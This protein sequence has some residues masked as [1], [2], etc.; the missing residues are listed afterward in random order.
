MRPAWDG[1]LLESGS[2][3]GAI[4]REASKSLAEL[5]KAVSESFPALLLALI[6]A[7]GSAT[8]AAA[9]SKYAGVVIDAKTGK[10]LYSDRA[11]ARRYPAS[12][13]KM[14]TLYLVFDALQTGR[15][16]MGTRIPVSRNAA[17]EVPS[18]LGLKPGQTITVRQ[19]IYALVTKSANDA[20]TAIGEFLGGS[21]KGFARMMTRRAHQ[22]GM[23]RTT[24][25]NA[26]GLPN[27]QQKTTAHDMARLG[28]ALREHHAKY[29][30]F[31][32]TRSFAYNGHRYGN[33]NR[34]LGRVKGVDGI[35]TGYTRASGFN[36]VTSVRRNGRSIVAVVMGG[37]TGR[38]RD[39]HM[40]DLIR[41]YLPRA[42]TGADR[43]LIARP[44]LGTGGKRVASVMLPASR[45]PVPRK[46]PA[47]ST[48]TAYADEPEAVGDAPLLAATGPDTPADED[49]DPVA[50]A[51]VGHGPWAIQVASL[52]SKSDALSFLE[53][54]SKAAPTVLANAEPFTETF[55]KDGTVYHRARYGGFR[56]KD[57]AWNACS[58]LKRKKIACYAIAQ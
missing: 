27:P 40:A 51:S 10:V 32:S 20:A 45:V 46:R 53:N 4:V 47:L 25:R 38:S 30:H 22:L 29:Y 44:A 19:V 50:T 36:L 12:L 41:R 17:S 57:A 37:R 56:S 9:N 26:N 8:G 1:R 24:F 14:M 39:R 49:L 58:A 18:K 43:D 52:P 7:V 15:I 54:T 11:E 3:W 42:S 21:E 6:V 48:L 23:T 55:N 5:F 28:L 31:F 34:L 16:T 2:E 13:T 35:K 33:H